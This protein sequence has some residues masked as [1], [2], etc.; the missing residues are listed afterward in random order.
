VLRLERVAVQLR[1]LSTVLLAG[2]NVAIEDELPATAGGE[3]GVAEQQI[4][5][6]ER[7]VQIME[8]AAA[9]LV[10]TASTS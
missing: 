8:R 7:Q 1:L 6:M 9:E 2:A 5:R 10:G 3:A 4:R